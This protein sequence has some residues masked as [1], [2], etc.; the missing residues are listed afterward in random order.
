MLRRAILHRALALRSE[1]VVGLKVQTHAGESLRV[2]RGSVLLIAVRSIPRQSIISGQLRPAPRS[3]KIIQRLFAAESE[4]VFPVAGVVDRHVPVNRIT[5]SHGRPAE[6]GQIGHDEIGHPQIP[7]VS[8]GT[9]ER[10]DSQTI[11]R[12]FDFDRRRDIFSEQCIVR[13]VAARH[14][15]SPRNLRFVE[16]L[17]QKR[18]MD[19]IDVAFVAL[20]IVACLKDFGHRPVFSAAR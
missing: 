10:V 4:N 12:D 3:H 2:H 16:T 13:G 20:E 18:K 8:P 11:V 1:R 17:M 9:S 7:F 14:S 19:R 15:S 6:D 5:L